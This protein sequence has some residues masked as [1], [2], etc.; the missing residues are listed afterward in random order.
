MERRKGEITPQK[1]V[2][3]IT[4]M[5]L[6]LS[7]RC[8]RVAAARSHLQPRSLRPEVS[9]AEARA[10]SSRRGSP[11]AVT[12]LRCPQ[13]HKLSPTHALP[14]GELRAICRTSRKTKCLSLTTGPYGC[15]RTGRAAGAS[16][17]E[18]RDTDIT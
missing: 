3:D 18:A 16:S 8:P 7:T 15:W 2:G 6:L 1:H 10:H 5:F 4:Q 12:L 11:E 17:Q 13:V 14:H 9:A